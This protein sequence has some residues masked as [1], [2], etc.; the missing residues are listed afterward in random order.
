MLNIDR[1]GL[2]LH[3][4]RF[5]LY[6]N[7]PEGDDPGSFA[8]HLPIPFYGVLVFGWEVTLGWDLY[9]ISPGASELLRWVTEKGHDGYDLQSVFEDPT[10]AELAALEAAM[11]IERLKENE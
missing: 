7:A 8:L 3:C 1:Y 5:S 10:D 9:R 2:D 6:I 4:G 11:S